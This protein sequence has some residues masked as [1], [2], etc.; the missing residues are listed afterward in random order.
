MNPTIKYGQRINGAT[1]AEGLQRGVTQRVLYG[2]TP[3]HAPAGN[4]PRPQRFGQGN[5][6]SGPTAEVGL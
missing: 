4:A 2:T 3:S 1:R 6:Q 5:A